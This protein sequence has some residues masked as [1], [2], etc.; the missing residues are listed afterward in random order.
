[1]L[2]DESAIYWSTENRIKK[3][4]KT[5]SKVVSILEEKYQKVSG[6]TGFLKNPTPSTLMLLK[7]VEKMAVPHFRKLP[8]I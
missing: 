2:S 3:D 8:E 1:M 6:V 7:H 4:T 5:F